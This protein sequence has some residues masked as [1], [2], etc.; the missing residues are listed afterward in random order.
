VRQADA[1]GEHDV[2]PDSTVELSQRGS[3]SVEA[4]TVMF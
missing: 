2:L 3:V 1:A 4:S